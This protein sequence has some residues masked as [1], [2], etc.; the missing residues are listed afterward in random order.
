M[1]SA[2]QP[3]P[4]AQLLQ[5][6]FGFMITRGVSAVAEL[7]VPDALRDGPQSVS[8]LAKA[9]GA[10]EGSLRRVMRTLVSIGAFAEPEPGTYA[11]TSVSELLRSDAA[12]SMRDLAVLITAQSHW[13]PWGQFADTV[14]TGESSAQHAFGTDVF[15]WFQR[16]ENKAQCDL[17]N[18]A[19]TS[20]SSGT[21]LAVAETYDFSRFTKVVDIGGGHGFLL[22]TILSKAPAARGVLFDLPGAVEGADREAL[23]ERIECVGGDFFEA[24]P[25]GGDCYTL[26][27]I[28]H[29][30]DDVHCRAIL[31]NIATAMVPTGSV[32]VVELVMPDG[33]EPHP[34]KFMDMNMLAMTEGGTERTKAE[35]VA[36]FSATGLELV[37]IYPTHGPVS[38]IEARKA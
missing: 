30:W 1:S 17:F 10:H 29:D 27:H 19:M 18:A 33:P 12:E 24:V 28:I 37:E 23:G 38:V 16:T 13:Q 15:S 11:L 22:T 36:L 34:A 25:Q 20:F 6:L 26:K 4:Q 35:Y 3:P 2:D 32:L 21:S 5:M 7:N 14:R 8:D 9:V 31:E